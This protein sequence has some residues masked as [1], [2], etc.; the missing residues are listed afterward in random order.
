MGPKTLRMGNRQR[1]L[2][3]FARFNVRIPMD[4][5]SLDFVGRFLLIVFSWFWG[6][7]LVVS[8]GGLVVALVSRFP[9][10][11]GLLGSGRIG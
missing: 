3:S 4:D 2:N 11:F 10:P 6:F 1:S 9:G 8:P 5:T 7:W